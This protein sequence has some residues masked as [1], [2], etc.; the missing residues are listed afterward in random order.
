MPMKINHKSYLT[1]FADILQ[2][3]FN[4]DNLRAVCIFLCSIPS[5]IQVFSHQ[6]RSV[7]TKNYTIRVHHRNHIKNI[8]FQQKLRLFGLLNKP[9]Y[10]SLTDIGTLCLARMLSC[11]NN[12]SLSIIP[13]FV[14]I[15]TNHQSL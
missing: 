11:H 15:L 4:S 9:I 3:R 6:V 1:L 2:K 13:F 12:N 8:I 5:S 10:N 7:M 14:Y